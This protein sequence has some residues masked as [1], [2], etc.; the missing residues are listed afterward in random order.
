[1]LA[2]KPLSIHFLRCDKGKPFYDRLLAAIPAKKEM[3]DA[4]AMDTDDENPGEVDIF[5]DS[6][7]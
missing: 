3:V 7:G 6:E 2:G 4:D 1:M 5:E